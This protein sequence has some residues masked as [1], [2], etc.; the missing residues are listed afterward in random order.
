MSE[1]TEEYRVMRPIALDPEDTE[2]ATQQLTNQLTAILTEMVDAEMED[3]ARHRES[4]GTPA[5]TQVLAGH[6]RFAIGVAFQIGIE[7]Q[8][9]RN[10]DHPEH[11]A[12]AQ[13]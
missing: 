10:E 13:N 8:R 3:R 5:F 6:M 12:D 4:T 1:D 11:R 2:V 7:W 9:H